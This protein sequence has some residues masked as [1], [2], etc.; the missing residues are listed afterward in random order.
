MAITFQ[1]DIS[2]RSS[3][4]AVVP[5]KTASTFRRP[6]SPHAG[7]D[8]ETTLSHDFRS[9]ARRTDIGTLSRTAPIPTLARADLTIRSDFRG[10]EAISDYTASSIATRMGIPLD[11]TFLRCCGLRRTDTFI[12]SNLIASTTAG[13]TALYLTELTAP[14]FT[15]DG[16]TA[17]EVI[18][19]IGWGTATGESRTVQTVRQA[20]LVVNANFTGGSGDTLTVVSSDGVQA[21]DVLVVDV[22]DAPN[23]EVLTVLSVPSATTVRFTANP[24]NNH[25]INDLIRLDGLVLSSAT[26][27]N[28]S[29]AD[30]VFHDVVTYFPET[31]Q[32]QIR[33]AAVPTAVPAATKTIA[34]MPGTASQFIAGDTLALGGAFDPNRESVTVDVSPAPETG[35]STTV[36]TAETGGTDAILAVGSSTGFA[37]GDVVWIGRG[38][39]NAERLIVSSTGAGTITFTATILNDHAV[40]ETVEEEDTITVTG[41]GTGGGTLFAHDKVTYVNAATTPD[42]VN[43]TVTVPSGATATMRVND[44][45][46]IAHGTANEEAILVAALTATTIVATSLLVKS[47]NRGEIVTATTLEATDTVFEASI[48]HQESG[49]QSSTTPIEARVQGLRGDASLVGASDEITRWEFAMA[50][51]HE[52]LTD[53]GKAGSSPVARPFFPLLPSVQPQVFA[54]TCLIM[55]PDPDPYEPSMRSFTVRMGNGLTLIPNGCTSSGVKGQAINDRLVQLEALVQWVPPSVF[56]WVG[57]YRLGTQIPVRLRVRRTS[58]RLVHISIPNGVVSA[59]AN[60][61][62][63]GLLYFRVTIDAIVPPGLSPTGD[64][65]IT[66]QYW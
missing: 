20:T 16:T 58:R 14:L 34:L 60:E 2:S 42:G 11:D 36:A 23:R 6:G 49:G 17:R 65:E 9:I 59:I 40:G 32:S 12:L 57:A 28:H 24:A 8:V 5:Q 35:A 25:A 50:G 44:K 22:G 46:W 21:G 4:T 15:T 52:E 47:H 48:A 45:L 38:T 51:G 13:A 3:L 54:E 30:R 26:S 18:V 56:D 66:F 33:D 1:P 29:A 53:P 62:I 61:E 63:D 39:A 37:N 10:P 19:A 43:K 31:D 7:L 64:N 27:R 41:L 55:G